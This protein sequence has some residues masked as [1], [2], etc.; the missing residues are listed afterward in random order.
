MIAITTRSSIRVKPPG[1]LWL[2]RD[3][4]GILRILKGFDTAKRRFVA[5]VLI[6]RPEKS[7]TKGVMDRKGT[8]KRRIRVTF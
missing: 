3:L 8:G 4:S 5:K 7:T 2:G 6:K 1:D